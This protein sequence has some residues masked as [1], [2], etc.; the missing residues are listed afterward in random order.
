VAVL[1]NQM[2]AFFPEIVKQEKLVTEVIK[3]E[4]NSFLKTI[5][6]GLVRLDHI[7]KDTI[8]KN[9]KVLPG[10]EVFELYDT[11]GFPADLSRIIAEE[12]QLTVDEKGFDEEMEKQKQRS[13]KSSAQKVYDWEVVAELPENFVGYD[14]TKTKLKLQVTEK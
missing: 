7:I 9:E 3:E 5:E 1:K 11:Y 13:K 4:E 8:S 10:A 14:K 2:G 6:H 12:K